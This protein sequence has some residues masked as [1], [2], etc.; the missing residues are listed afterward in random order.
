MI[1]SSHWQGQTRTTAEVLVALLD[2]E[3]DLVRDLGAFRGLHALCAEEGRDSDEKE[4][5]RETA[6]DHFGED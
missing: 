4:P 5:K 3:V 1:Y 6:E 2:V